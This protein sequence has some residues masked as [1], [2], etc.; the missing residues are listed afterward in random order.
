MTV[1]STSITVL[2]VDDSELACETVKHTLGEAGLNV[3]A[4]NSPFGFIKAIR[5]S[6]PAVILVDVSLGILNGAKLVRLGRQHAPPGCSL[7]L[8]SSRDPSV[9][10]QD[11]ISSGADGYITKSTTG[12]DFVAAIDRWI[13]GQ[14]RK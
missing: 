13:G 8:Y 2:V 14:G 5:E 12:R 11:V 4:L 1:R 3:I 6:G 10:E 7:L 9:L